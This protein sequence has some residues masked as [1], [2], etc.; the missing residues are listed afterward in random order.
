MKRAL[1][2]LL[3]LI[4]LNPLPRAEAAEAQV[5]VVCDYSHTLPDDAVMMP[6]MPGMAMSHDFFGN[7]HTNAYSTNEQLVAD[8]STT[9]NNLADHSAYWAP[10]LRLPDGQVIRPAYQ[11]TY[12]QATNVKEFPLSPFPAGLQLLAGT[13]NGTSPNKVA[14]DYFCQGLGYSDVPKS[15]CPPQADGTVQMNIAIKFPNCWDG[16][17]LHPAIGVRNA[18]Y[19]VNNACPAAYPVKLPTVNMNIAY[20]VPNSPP[21]DMTKVELSLDPKMVEG[22]VVEQW[23]S[24]YSAHADFMN[25]WPDQASDYMVNHCMNRALDCGLN[26]PLAYEPALQDVTVSN[27]ESAESNFAGSSTLV[28][29]DNWQN[30]RSKNREE[31]GLIQFAIPAWPAALDID[32]DT[33]FIYKVRLFGNNVSDSASRQLFLYPTSNDWQ[34]QAVTWNSRPSCGR[35]ADGKTQVTSKPSYLYFSVDAAVKRAIKNKQATIS[36]CIGGE[37]Q[38]RIY[39]FDATES[40]NPPLLI[41]LGVKK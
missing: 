17:T 27:Q 10:S 15:R 24:I 37:R 1:P 23:G 20:L 41:L 5:H 26:V 29:Q 28:V 14:I 7:T 9:C 18:D 8:F 39:H 6:A 19:A 4:W 38:G 2:L 40:G 33:S 21:I 36:F 11:K 31:V 16:V 32:K 12:Y 30:D 22:K 35:D 3:M 13:H 34:E 25:G